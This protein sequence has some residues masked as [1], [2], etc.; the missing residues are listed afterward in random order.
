[1][2]KITVMGADNQLHTITLGMKE[3]WKV[4]TKESKRTFVL[5][6]ASTAASL[7]SIILPKPAKYVSLAIGCGLA[8]G[9]VVSQIDCSNKMTSQ[10]NIDHVNNVLHDIASREGF[11]YD[12]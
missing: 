3:L 7:A 6:M 11:E 10:E 1:M 2:K 9:T 5:G 8:A 4:Q 12:C